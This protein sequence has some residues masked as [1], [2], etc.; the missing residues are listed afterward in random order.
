MG[1]D[2][3]HRLM[4]RAVNILDEKYWERGGATDRAFSRAGVRGEIGVNESAYYYNYGWNAKPR[5]F[6]LQ[7][8]Y[9]F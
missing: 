2:K 5:S 4:V 7:Y 1:E 3:Q 9:N 6:Y 8:E